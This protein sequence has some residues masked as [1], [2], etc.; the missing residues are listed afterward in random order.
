MIDISVIVLSYYHERYMAKVL[1]RIIKPYFR[2]K[3][4]VKTG[5]DFS[6]PVFCLEKTTHRA[7][8]SKECFC[9]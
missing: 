9:R 2:S 6:S 8:G 4:Y 1:G 7:N 3:Y 5:R